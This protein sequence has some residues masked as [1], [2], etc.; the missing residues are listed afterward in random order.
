M[1]N[2]AEG[3]ARGLAALGA[4]IRTLRVQATLDDQGLADR[5]E[6]D[7]R[8][9]QELESGQRDPTWGDLRRIARGLDTPLEN[10]LELADTLEQG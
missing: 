8:L 3:D 6:V 2:R 5:A 7:L 4:A 9:L 10:L 1:S